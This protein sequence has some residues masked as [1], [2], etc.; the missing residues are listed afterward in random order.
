[1]LL[2]NPRGAAGSSDLVTITRAN[3]TAAL[4]PQNYFE[5]STANTKK[6]VCQQSWQ[7]AG[8]ISI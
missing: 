3:L 4:I 6:T 2:G 5:S 7:T 1:M 8:T